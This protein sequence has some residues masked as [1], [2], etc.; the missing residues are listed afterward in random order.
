MVIGDQV[1]CERIAACWEAFRVLACLR[2]E[3]HELARCQDGQRILE[4]MHE[5][6]AGGLVASTRA[7]AAVDAVDRKPVDA[8]V[9]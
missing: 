7:L 8:E 9:H 5:L 3:L 1:T 4:M 6:V 2:D